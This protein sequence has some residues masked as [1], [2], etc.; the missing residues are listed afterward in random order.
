M[1][2]QT[3]LAN[4]LWPLL[5]PRIQAMI[6]AAGS[7]TGGG[8]GA[9]NLAAHDL[10]GS[11]HKGTLRSDQA[12]QFLLLDGTRPLAG[13]LAVDAGVMIDGVDISAHAADPDAH[14]AKLHGITD[15]AH[16]SVTGSQYQIVGLTAVNTLGL[17][18]PS[19]TPAANAIVKTD[20]SS[21]VTFVDVTVTSDLFVTGHLDFGTDTMYEDA[22]YLQVT[23]SKAVRFGQNIGNANWTVFNAGGA[24]FGGNVEIISGGDLTVAGSGSYAGN[25]VL[26][27]DSSGGNVGIM[28]APDSQ[29]ALDI[30]GPAR[31]TYWIGPHAIQLK[32]VLM[33]C[34]Y[35]GREPVA[36]NFTGDPN[37]HMGQIATVTGGVVFR[38]GRYYK[39]IQI[40]AYAVNLVTNPSFETGTTGW[41]WTD[42]N[43]SG[44][45][46]ATT[47]TY[48][49]YHTGSGALRLSNGTAGEN[50][51]MSFNVTGLS[52]STA[53]TISAWCR[54]VS[55]SG[56]A[57]GSRGLTAYDLDNTSTL[58]TTTITAV[59]DEWIRH[60]VTVTTT[61]TAG[62]HTIQI[63]LYA[64]QGYVL[65]D[66]VQCEQTAYATPYL[67]GTLA[68]FD[69]N[70][71]WLDAGVAGTGHGWTGTA[72]AS[73]SSRAGGVV[74]YPTAGNINPNV[75]TIM[76]WVNP[77]GLTG[78]AQT[79]LRLN[80]T[81][82][83]NIILR[84]DTTGKPQA[85]AGT[86]A[87]TAGSAVTVNTW[88]HV[89]MSYD[90]VTAKLYVN[91]TLA[92]S[93]TSAGFSG[94]PATMYVGCHNTADKF[95][96][97][98]D[99]L[100]IVE[101]VLPADEI[102]SVYESN[103]PVFAETSTFVFRPTPKGLIWADDEG[104]W[105][106]DSAGNPVLGVYGGEAA[107]KSWAGFTLAAGDIA[108]GRNAVGSSA[109]WWD[110]SAGKFGFYGAGSGTPQVEIATDGKLVAGA[111]AVKLDSAG[112]HA[113]NASAVATIDIDSNGIYLGDGGGRTTVATWTSG[114]R[115]RAYNVGEMYEATPE[116]YL[117][118][119]SI[120][121]TL[122]P[123]VVRAI[124]QGNDAALVEISAVNTSN[125]GA[126]LRVGEGFRL[127][128]YYG[129]PYFSNRVVHASA[130]D[131]I[132][133]ATN[134]QLRSLTTSAAAV[135][136]YSGKIRINIGGTNYYIPYYA[137]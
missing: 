18:T 76:A 118:D 95:N 88:T 44:S 48:G 93:G 5:L 31:A 47:N 81:T 62:S 6:A 25:T 55:F 83:G 94:L 102:R 74:T 125:V 132:L 121:R 22:S 134:L 34:H 33:L 92:A 111:G 136:A 112:F 113:F 91:G 79:V 103:A 84:L 30:A 49:Y 13:S 114:N 110:Q 52:A 28:R 20:S 64:P 56:A 40:A 43:A 59:A 131:I 106:R 9:A 12:P 15:A 130:T 35:D 50:D 73:T 7:G 45:T 99:D 137:S 97:L 123:L 65:W 60:V 105:M 117:D 69:S 119:S 70:G 68:G 115:I 77:A 100:V 89:A 8:S 37:G 3:Q 67:D 104:L 54:V 75:G 38:Q 19:A 71:V 57:F 23:G 39:G 108:F 4:D 26:F 32:N 10:G 29:F 27:A 78:A 128:D 87:V 46:P 101:R 24:Q 126:F 85:Y 135:G 61:A 127:K 129:T 80:G 36:T 53:Y 96:G 116:T 122:Y 90:G 109:I 133:E 58:Q 66:S 21:A 1:Q 86:A 41:T 98:I 51:Y 124:R 107:T 14:H 16:H 72:H 2:R 82:A 63:R 11:L 42:A 120:S 17:L